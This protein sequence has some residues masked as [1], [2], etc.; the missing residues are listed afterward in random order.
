MLPIKSAKERMGH[1][2]RETTDHENTSEL[3][4]SVMS[5]KVRGTTEKPAHMPKGEGGHKCAHCGKDHATSE[6]HKHGREHVGKKGRE[7]MAAGAE[8]MGHAEHVRA[9]ED[10][11]KGG[12]GHVH[13]HVHHHHHMAKE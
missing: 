4:G 8:K 12:K 13:V 10:A 9:G 2:K 11:H 6:H 7:H 3:K 5:K 1:A